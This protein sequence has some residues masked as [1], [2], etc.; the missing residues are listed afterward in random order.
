MDTANGRGF[1]GI[2]IALN[3]EDENLKQK[4]V[5]KPTIIRSS[6]VIPS[7]ADLE[8]SA[9]RDGCGGVNEFLEPYRN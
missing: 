7:I 3:N 2:I 1:R 8:A 6:L 9:A 5:Y 4:G